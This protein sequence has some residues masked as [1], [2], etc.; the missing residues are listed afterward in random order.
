MFSVYGLTGQVSRGDVLRA[1]VSDP[2]L[3]LWR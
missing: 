2:P 3:S 1:V